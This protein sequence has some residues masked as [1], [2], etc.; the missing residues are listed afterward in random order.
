MAQGWTRGTAMKDVEVKLNPRI[1]RGA[2]HAFYARNN[3]CE[4]AYGPKMAATVLR[5]PCVSVGAFRN[6]ELIGFARALFD[7]LSATIVEFCLDL[8]F[9]GSNGARNGCFVDSDPHGIA[10][11]M[12]KGL[13]RELR[14]RGCRFFSIT[15]WSAGEQAFY[16]TLGFKENKGAKEFVIDERPYVKKRRHPRRARAIRRT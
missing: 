8:R 16:R 13:L 3:I 1:A 7:G 12:A 11:R 5:H 6:G 4:A 2:L 14:R 9:Q 10:R 15:V